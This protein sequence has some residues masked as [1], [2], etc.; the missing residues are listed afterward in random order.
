V[1]LKEL[2]GWASALEGARQVYDF[3]PEKAF[4]LAG[5]QEAREGQTFICSGNEVYVAACQTGLVRLK[6]GQRAFVYPKG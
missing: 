4:E 3:V 6:N 1:K 5:E 2:P